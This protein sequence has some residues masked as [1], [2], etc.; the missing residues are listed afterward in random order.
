MHSLGTAPKIV[1]IASYP[2]SGNTW[3]RIFLQNL[4][5][6]MAGREGAPDI[7]ALKQFSP[8]DLDRE[9]YDDDSVLLRTD[10]D[11]IA[12]FIPYRLRALQ[13]LGADRQAPLFV[14]THCT[15]G[16]IGG[17]PTIDPA[18]TRG[19]VYIVRN[20][21]DVAVSLARHIGQPFDFVVKL[22]CMPNA[23]T[24]VAPNVI[25]FP[26]SWSQNV[27]SWTSARGNIC[28]LR[29]EDLLDAP[30]VAFTALSNRFFNPRPNDEQIRRAIELS[31][32]D[33]L[34]AEEQRHGFYDASPHARFFQEGRAGG[35][36]ALSRDHVDWIVANNG[37]QMRRFGYL[38]E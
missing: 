30:N 32:I 8:W 37:A 7:N 34:R 13:R 27:A 9:Y 26:A 1:W 6:I 25:D 12:R 19:A 28:V 17:Q 11:A 24:W 14:K 21:L 38:S 33:Q 10:P 18:I 31:Q 4:T 36:D 5:H 29:Y 3:I 22:M 35:R 2:R 15:F 16:L 23:C 20:P